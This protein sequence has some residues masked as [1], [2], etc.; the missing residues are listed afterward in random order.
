MD[1][2]FH[3]SVLAFFKKNRCL[4]CSTLEAAICRAVT[5]GTCLWYPN[6]FLVCGTQLLSYI[7]KY[8]RP[9]IKDDETEEFEQFLNDLPE[10]AEN[11]D[12]NVE[13]FIRNDSF[14]RDFDDDDSYA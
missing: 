10:E 2:S 14:I 1:V 5:R 7:R 8:Y 9:L 13:E 11:T 4:N 6:E 12:P 3:N